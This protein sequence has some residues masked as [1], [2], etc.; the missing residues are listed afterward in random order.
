MAKDSIPVDLAPY[1][2]M[3]DGT[4]V[5]NFVEWA[6]TLLDMTFLS[7]TVSK[8]LGFKYAMVV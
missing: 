5:K 2:G 6:R 4:D 3:H 7:E 8:G 1:T